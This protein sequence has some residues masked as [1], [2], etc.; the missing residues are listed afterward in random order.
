MKKLLLILLFPVVA[1]AEQAVNVVTV[2]GTVVKAYP[3]AV[4]SAVDQIVQQTNTRYQKTYLN[5]DGTVTIVEPWYEIGG[6]KLPFA[7]WGTR[8]SPE[9]EAG[10]CKLYGFKYYYG[11]VIG[12][13]YGKGV[14][15]Y[16]SGE[17]Y[18]YY[19]PA[20]WGGAFKR[21]SKIVCGN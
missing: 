15:L 8:S 19:Y 21:T 3:S 6:E 10:I 1:S 16:R 9:N 18:G 12:S 13:A 14:E 4:A 17:F 5:Q 7:Y 2:D 20:T 11:T